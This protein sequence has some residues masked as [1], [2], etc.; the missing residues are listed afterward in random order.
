MLAFALTGDSGAG[1]SHFS[2]RLAKLFLD[3]D[4]K[5][6]YYS[7]EMGLS[8]SVKN[9]I[10]KYECQEIS[11]VGKA[12]IKVIKQDTKSYDV[13]II[14]SFGKL[15]VKPD[16]FDRLRHDFPYTIFIF[17]FQKTNSGGMRGGS[18]ILFDSSATID[19]E[20]RDGER[21]AVMKKSR[22]GTQG[23]EYS[24][25]NDEIAKRGE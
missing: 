14:D 21:V 16:V 2:Y 10:E 6:K 5:V 7:L 9:L 17:I 4:F 22:Y 25:T 3:A 12:D 15:N 20:L 13:L 18:S 8:G 11:I 19:I 1:K 23:W 24:I